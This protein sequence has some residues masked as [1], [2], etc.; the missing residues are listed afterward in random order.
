[1]KVLIVDDEPDIREV[2]SIAFNLRWPDAKVLTAGNG[3]QGL[4]VALVE[5]PEVII[6]DL[7]L[8]DMSGFEVCQKL[9]EI[10]SVPIL[11]LTARDSEVEK[12][13]GL[14]MGAD[15]F[16]TKP[17][18]HLEL[19]ARVRAILRRHHSQNA[20]GP[21]SKYDG[22][23]LSIDFGARTVLL[24]GQQIDLPPLEYSLL[25]HLVKNADRVV[26]HKTLL[27]KVWGREYADQVDYLKVHIQRLRAKLEEE[28]GNPK[29]IVTERGVGYR[30]IEPQPSDDELSP[31]TNT[32]AGY[33]TS[34][35]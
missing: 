26:P 14:E 11:F 34:D 2:I 24:N 27:A 25:Y 21:E 15:D 13:K 32:A 31:Q 10:T 4:E 33:G 18:N 28:P 7:S 29:L 5:K 23:K 22:G 17:F 19:L 1:M 16:I 12:V 6:L 8:P 35:V 20:G 30:F 3:T 9:R